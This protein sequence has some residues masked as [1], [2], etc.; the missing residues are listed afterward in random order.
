MRIS[1]FAA[2]ALAAGL[3]AGS[4]TADVLTFDGDI[5]NGGQ[6]CANGAEIDETYGD[7]TGVDVQYVDDRTDDNL[8]LQWWAESYSDLTNVAWGG[9]SD[10]VGSPTIRLVALSGYSVNL[11][12]FDLGA[13]PNTDRTTQVTISEIGGGVLY[14]SGQITI[15]AFAHTHFGTNYTSS[16]GFEINW[17]PNGYNVGIDN[18]EFTAERTGAIVPE[19]STWAL[20][21]G[22]FGLAG[23]A[24]R[25]RRAVAA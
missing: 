3:C 2:A 24:L 14:S 22:G 9:D 13:W 7:T 17:G 6:A 23:G 11:L 12:G 1:L 18:I 4:A 8:T 5:C 10:E 15:D 19:P 20:M 21:I 16:S 25:R